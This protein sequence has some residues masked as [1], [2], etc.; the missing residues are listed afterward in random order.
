VPN[1]DGEM[2]ARTRS[3]RP[4]RFRR[5]PDH[6]R[7]A[8]LVEAS[9]V[10]P[11]LM[12]LIFGVIEVG[13]LLKSYSSTANSVRAGGRMASVQGAEALADQ[14]IMERM[15]TEAV[16]LGR[17]E[18]QYVIIFNAN[19]PDGTVPAGCVSAAEALSAPNTSSV[20]VSDGGTGA[21]GACNVYVR[22][23]AAGGAFDMARNRLANPPD[24]YFGCNGPSDPGVGHRV[25]CRWPSRNRHTTVSPRVLAP[26]ET[27]LVPDYL[28]IYIK[29]EHRYLAGILGSTRILTD[30]TVNLLEP[31]SFGVGS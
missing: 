22:P 25:D 17:G 23:Q 12:F 24:Y 20:G 30:S 1:T 11:V 6:D 31:D 2:G 18:I 4:R 19:G 5:R 13:G 8:V 26:G 21:V 10:L 15:A 27:R 3:A 14:A 28:G 9:V 29:V 16:G 7:G